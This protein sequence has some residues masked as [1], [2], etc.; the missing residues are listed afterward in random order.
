MAR[1][2][3]SAR[4]DGGRRLVGRPSAPVALP[5]MR[6]TLLCIAGAVAL[7]TFLTACGDSDSGSG[8][9]PNE[10]SPVDSSVTVGAQD[11]LQ[12]DADAYEAGAGCVEITYQNEGGVPHTLLIKGQSGFKLSIG[13]E[14]TGKIA[15][16]A[17]TYTIFCDI[18]GH[19]SAGMAAELTVS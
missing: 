2:Y 18:A 10:C 4:G 5:V 9:A 19:E 1:A 16:D 7:A 3:R 17:G 11:E 14:D 6:R 8:A 13:D 15:L 12:F